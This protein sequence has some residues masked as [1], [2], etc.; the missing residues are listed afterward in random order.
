M[1]LNH[2]QEQALALM[3]NGENIFLTGRAGTGKS[4]VVEAFIRY[5]E[6]Q[7][8]RSLAV[9]APTGIAALNIGGRTI[10]EFFK[11]SPSPTSILGAYGRMAEDRDEVLRRCDIILIDEI[12]MVSA[13]L[14]DAIDRSLRQARGK[15]HD[16]FGGAQIIMFGDPYQLP[17]VPP[18]TQAMAFQDQTGF[19]GNDGQRRDQPPCR[20]EP[21]GAAD[22]VFDRQA[23]GVETPTPFGF[24]WAAKTVE[25]GH[26]QTGAVI[27]G[28]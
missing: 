5:C 8:N 6:R 1:K 14:M 22:P 15:R 23:L 2:E 18:V 26:R 16:P 20:A 12:S 10:H 17:P 13:D 27:F 7:G 21:A 3:L 4:T 11:L 25:S 19:I 28:A 24:T 9:L